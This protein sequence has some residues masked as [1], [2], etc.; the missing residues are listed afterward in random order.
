MALSC[1]RGGSGWMLQKI[2]SQKMWQCIVTRCPEWWWSHRPWRCLRNLGTVGHGLMV[3][4]WTRWSVPI[5][6]IL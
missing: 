3:D 5:L 4:G 2:S 6:T 1:F